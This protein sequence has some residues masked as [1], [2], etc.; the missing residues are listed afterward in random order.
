VLKGVEPLYGFLHFADQD[1]ISNMSKALLWFNMCI[2]EYE[3]LFHDYP[4]DLEQYMRVIK[5]RIGTSQTKHSSMRVL[6]IFIH[7]TLMQT[8]S[9]SPCNLS[10]SFAAAALNPR[11]HYGYDTTTSVM[12]D[13]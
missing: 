7:A 11:T 2:G 9:T 3:S 1:K 8:I 4:N 10:Y 12:Q 6:V 5:S 13:L